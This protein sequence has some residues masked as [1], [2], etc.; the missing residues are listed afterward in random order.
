MVK[1]VRQ[2]MTT[3]KFD[4]NAAL[5]IALKGSTKPLVDR[6]QLF[7]SITSQRVDRARYFV[8]V[9]KTN[10]RYNIAAAIHEGA[11]IPVTDKMRGLFF[12]LWLATKDPKTKARDK[13]GRFRATVKM[14]SK[15]AEE[16]KRI[17]IRRKVV[18]FPLKAST[19]VI[20]VPR[21]PFIEQTFRDRAIVEKL[22]T[23]WQR[24]ISNAMRGVE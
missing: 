21:R 17:A 15:R 2:R 3:A 8:G 18:I 20:R 9:L 22:R 10:N 5:T 14:K 7:Q 11:S 4:A 6:G 12:S 23:H 1:Y 13:A 16:L 24:A 19:T